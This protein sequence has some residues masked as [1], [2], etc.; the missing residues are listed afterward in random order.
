M[1]DHC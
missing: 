1:F